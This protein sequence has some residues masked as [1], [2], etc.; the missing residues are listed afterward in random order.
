MLI[1]CLDASMTI[2]N[3]NLPR[4]SGFN[5]AFFI[6]PRG[7]LLG[8]ISVQFII[9]KARHCNFPRQR[10]AFAT[11]QPIDL[12]SYSSY[13]WFTLDRRSIFS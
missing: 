4:K 1:V 2:K 8:F 12:C 10:V 11:F 5:C 3:A 7:V 9:Q 13:A 6:Y